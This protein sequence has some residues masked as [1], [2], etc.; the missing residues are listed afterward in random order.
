VRLTTWTAVCSECARRYWRQG[1]IATSLR[2]TTCGSRECRRAHRLR[3][4]RHGRDAAA[5]I[6]AKLRSFKT[7]P[8][9][10]P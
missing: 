5:A 7:S 10:K 8:F 2:D 3:V 4:E 9:L 6:D 1:T